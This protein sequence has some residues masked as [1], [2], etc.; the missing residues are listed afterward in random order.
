MK[1]SEQNI[2]ENFVECYK[3]LVYS[4]PHIGVHNFRC[5][6]S[7]Y[8]DQLSDSRNAYLCFEGDGI[9]DCYYTYGSRWDKTCSDLSYSNK[10]E[11]CY[12]CVDAEECYNGNFLQDCERCTDCSYCYDCA[13]CQNCFGC[14]GLRRAEYHIFNVRYSKED[15]EKKLIEVRKMLQEKIYAEMEK[16]RLKHPHVATHIRRS[17]NCSGDY[18]FDSKNSQFIF[19]GH[20]LEDCVYV[21]ESKKLKDCVDLETAHRNELCYEA[22][23]NMDNYNSNFYYWCADMRNCEFMMYCFNTEE[24]FGCFFLKRKKFHILNE[25]YEG[26]RYF[27]M[28]RKI[29]ENL[30]KKNQ[31]KNFLPDIR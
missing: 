8:S 7:D 5:E 26:K 10:C 31:Y 11:L 12:E 1:F 19:K 21:N 23:E 28:V 4:L 2:I 3:K 25:P 17:E 18:I 22:I 13:S 30:S 16:L 9:E 20:E 24:C 14:V 15:Y 27:E 29:K 6:N